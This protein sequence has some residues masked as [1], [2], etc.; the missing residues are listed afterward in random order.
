MRGAGPCEGEDEEGEAEE[1]KDLAGPV[2]CSEA[3]GEGVAGGCG[4]R[5]DAGDGLGAEEYFAEE[6]GADEDSGGGKGEVYAEAPP[7]VRLCEVSCSML[8]H[9]HQ[10]RCKSTNGGRERTPDYRP[11]TKRYPIDEGEHG[12]V[13]VTLP[14]RHLVR[15]NH[16]RYDVEPRARDALQRA[17]EEED[18]ERGGGGTCAEGASDEDDDHVGLEGCVAAEDVAYCPPE[19]GM[20]VTTWW[21]GGPGGRG[22]DGRG[23][24]GK[25]KEVLSGDSLR[26]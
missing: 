22:R 2:Y 8:A 17:A 9:Q 14:Q 5:V 16:P 11:Y 6:E 10:Y 15:E 4:G 1:E 18:G 20:L 23:R 24:D 25:G 19:L 21:H 7:P 26:E 13:L 3:V 12:P